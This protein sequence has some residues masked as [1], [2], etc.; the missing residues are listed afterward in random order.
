RIQ[1]NHIQENYTFVN[2]TSGTYFLSI[3]LA[4]SDDENN[5]FPREYIRETLKREQNKLNNKF[6][7]PISRIVENSCSDSTCKT[8]VCEEVINFENK[9]FFISANNLN[10]ISFPHYHQSKCVCPEGF[11]GEKCEN[12]INQCAHQPCPAYQ[13][14]IPVSLERGYLCQ[15][16]QGLTGH[17]CSRTKK[18]CSGKENNIPGCY[19][20][21][22]PLTLKGKSYLKYVI[23][24]TMEMQFS[25]SI[26][27][28]TLYASGNIMFVTGKIDYCNLEVN[29]GRVQYHWELGSGKGFISV[30]SLRVD[31][32]LWHHVILKQ[33]GNNAQVCI[34]KMYCKG[35]TSPGASNLLNLEMSEIYVGA[36]VRS[37]AGVQNPWRGFVGCIDSP[38]FNNQPLPQTQY[39]N[40]KVASL[41]IMNE[42]RQLCVSIPSSSFCGIY[43]CYN[44]GTCK[45]TN[46]SFMCYCN[47][48]YKGLRCEIDTDACASYPCLH[49]GH[50]TNTDKGF[51]CK[52]SVGVSG[53][54]CQY[55]YCSP[56]PCL[57]NAECEEGILGPI[58][59]CIGFTG[60]YCNLDINEC[61]K[62][63]CRNGGICTNTYGSFY[64]TCPRNTS[65][66]F[67]EIQSGHLFGIEEVF[68]IVSGIGLILSLSL[69]TLLALCCCRQRQLKC[70]RQQ[71]Q[72]S[73]QLTLQSINTHNH[74][75]YQR[76]TN[77][78]NMDT[79]QNE[80]G[81]TVHHQI[82]YPTSPDE[83]A[84]YVT[85]NYFNTIRCY[86][87]AED[88]LQDFP[89]YTE[90]LLKNVYKQDCEKYY[91]LQPTKNTHTIAQYAT[92]G[93]NTKKK[94]WN[95]TNIGKCVT[96]HHSNDKKDKDFQ[97]ENSSSLKSLGT[98]YSNKDNSSIRSS[99]LRLKSNVK[100]NSSLR[101]AC[102]L[103]DLQGSHWNYS[104]WLKISQ[105][106][107]P[108]NLSLED[109]RSPNS[110]SN[111]S[112]ESAVMIMNELLSKSV[113]D[114]ADSFVLLSADKL[115]SSY[116]QEI[117]EAKV[118]DLQ[119]T[120][121]INMDKREHLNSSLFIPD[122]Q[123]FE[124]N[125]SRHLCWHEI[126]DSKEDKTIMLKTI[127][128]LYDSCLSFSPDRNSHNLQDSET[129]EPYGFT[130]PRPKHKIHPDGTTRKDFIRTDSI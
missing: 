62:N 20:P 71:C 46:S 57:N 109:H 53:S 38:M 114:S 119:Q 24:I 120:S 128:D 59:K 69:I 116:D 41:Q 74:N 99:S 93:R 124:S 98:I 96:K 16:P 39:G 94:F 23:H 42:I 7:V 108:D 45:E 12:I 25:M 1:I 48:R 14:C 68:Y 56:N 47:P 91:T 73:N 19:I 125:T 28:Q 110:N 30:Y 85:L 89:D 32:G 50:C 8:G 100:D 29:R 112:I 70:Q 5:Y 44:G 49:N 3:L 51:R 77:I 95:N 15:C 17:N 34:D 55:M 103:D 13:K 22:S 35:S 2:Q 76:N 52:C 61:T 63:P 66:A 6:H 37:L 72:Q 80:H 10:F 67:C 21:N 111:D 104:D 88:Q 122:I 83:P 4:V 11:A 36:E 118:S 27:F 127:D 75:I 105:N 87:S 129:E 54:R 33:S 126:G 43:P 40:T 58:C 90:D 60:T 18:E 92:L 31:D 9:E 121:K 82:T 86:G 81:S 113:D 107:P 84:T 26:W 97:Q 102:S 115:V 64:C 130:F 101:S 65:G 79:L 78:L 123:R 117:E 106:T